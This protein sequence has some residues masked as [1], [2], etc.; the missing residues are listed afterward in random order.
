MET[1]AI[2]AAIINGIMHAPYNT[3]NNSIASGSTI[4]SGIE[5]IPHNRHNDHFG[6]NSIRSSGRRVQYNHMIN[7]I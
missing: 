4:L 5:K 1:Q 7:T 2:S 3:V 6:I